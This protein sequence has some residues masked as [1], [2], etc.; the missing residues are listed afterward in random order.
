M[1]LMFL[2]SVLGLSCHS[3]WVMEFRKRCEYFRCREMQS[4]YS[5][6]ATFPENQISFTSKKATAKGKKQIDKDFIHFTPENI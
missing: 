6:K 1:Y 5:R 4:V 3:S 2:L